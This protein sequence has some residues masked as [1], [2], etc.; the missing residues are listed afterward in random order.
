MPVNYQ[1]NIKFKNVPE[2]Q[3]D[4][5]NFIGGLVTDVHETKLEP[6][7]AS[8]LANIIYNS[9]KSIKTRNGFTRYNND[10]IGI[11]SD[12]ANTGAS[13]G[14][15]PI[16]A[17][18]DFVAQTFVPSGTINTVQI[19]AYLAMQTSGQTQYVRLE[20]WSTT[21]GEPTSLITNGKSQIKLISGTGE[22][23]YNFRFRQPVVLTTGTTY[24]IVIK[25]FVRG[26]TQTVNQVNVYHRGATYANGSVYTST[27]TGITWTADTN[28]DLRFEVFSGGDTGH[29]GLL[30]YYNDSG[31]QQLLT[32]V[33]AS[34]YRGD[35]ITGAMTAITL[36][37]LTLNADNYIDST[38][39]NNTLLIVDGENYIKKYRGS[40]NANYST[41]TISVTNGSSSVTGSSTVWNTSTNAE[42]NEYIKL[43]DNKWY[44]ILSIGSD[45]SL[46]IEIDYE[47]STLAGQTYTIS[48]WG[49]VQGALSSSTA[50]ANQT[51]PTPSYIENHLNRIWTIEGNTL[52]F[53]ALDTSI[54]E[55]HFNDFDTSNN[56][57]TIIIPSGKGDT[58]T[59]LYSMNGYLYVFQRNAIWEIFGTSPANFELRSISNELGLT[60]RRTLVE[61]DRFIIFYSGKDIYLFDGTNFKNLSEGKVGTLIDDWASI[62]SP[63]A[64]LWNNNY[65]ISYT[66]S[67]NSYNS[68]ALVY[69]IT[70]DVFSKLENIYINCWSSWTGGTDTGQ[71]YFGSSNQGSIYRWD[72]G[73]NDDGYEITTR[74]T[75]GSIGLGA[76]MNDKAI[77]RFYLQQLALGDYNMTVT[78]FTDITENETTGTAINLLSGATSLWDTAVWDTDVWSAEGSIVTNRV[79]EFQGIAKY[80]KFIFDQEG[81]DEGIEI[82]G[83]NVTARM[84]RLQ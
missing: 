77:K 37:S 6:N 36:P 16:T 64:V 54:T 19:D 59:G 58:C 27:D 60:S 49:D 38:M 68:E 71:I 70:N 20:I 84:R 10:P 50:V 55:E 15:L 78:Q 9:T 4:E 47:G 75:T 30:R 83:M 18:T 73:G 26:S 76:N 48:P 12:Q 3:L 41:G 17:T 45:T 43:P 56:A 24:A 80:F 63:S 34:F 28:K 32:K 46:E 23:E 35:D 69:D 22:T 74:Y 21:A 31:V 2:E 44:K 72:V 81:Y 11:A 65:I 33:G 61:F 53:S 79:A 25:P 82:L 40:T 62:T 1:N 5:F 57:G 52:R 39:T 51:R 29:T 67:G 14:S 42:A 7:Q 8:D 13:T 66:T